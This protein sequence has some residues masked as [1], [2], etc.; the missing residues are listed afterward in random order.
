MAH[1]DQEVSSALQ[2]NVRSYIHA[3]DTYR[4]MDVDE[5]EGFWWRARPDICLHV[6]VC[7]SLSLRPS[8]AQAQFL[9]LKASNVA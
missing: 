9:S 1:N 4:N 5:V 7:L 8:I 3:V 2:N 6:H